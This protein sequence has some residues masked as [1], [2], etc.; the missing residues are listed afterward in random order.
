MD[1][2][3]TL[4]WDKLWSS[5]QR[6]RTGIGTHFSATPPVNSTFDKIGPGGQAKTRKQPQL[7]LK[8]NPVAG[9][10]STY[11]YNDFKIHM[12]TAD[13]TVR[14]SQDR[15]HEQLGVEE[16]IFTGSLPSALL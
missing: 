13:S 7:N 4:D 5:G 8:A 11:C 10:P 12:Y 15:E 9:D 6:V 1:L 16:S 2:H 3:T 14:R